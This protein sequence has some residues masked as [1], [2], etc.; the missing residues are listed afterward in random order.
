MEPQVLDAGVAQ[1][2]R[3]VVGWHEADQPADPDDCRVASRPPTM[4]RP[5]LGV[6]RPVRIRNR[7]DFPAPFGPTTA[8]IF[9]LPAPS[10]RPCSTAV[11]QSLLEER[12]RTRSQVSEGIWGLE[13]SSTEHEYV[14]DRDIGHWG[15][16][17][18]GSGT[19][20]TRLQMSLAGTGSRRLAPRDL[21][22]PMSTRRETADPPGTGFPSQPASKNA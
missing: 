18:H 15:L 13:T 1:V 9:T 7:V 17:A 5:L 14:A 20:Q 22:Q 2:E 4:A 3:T 10:G 6:V 11:T 19:V 16:P 12:I 21:I 8:H